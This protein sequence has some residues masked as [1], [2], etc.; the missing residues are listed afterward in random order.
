M[1][2][3]KRLHP[4]KTE[5]FMAHFRVLGLKRGECRVNVIR[6]AAE[7]MSN[8]L[9]HSELHV[10]RETADVRRA[11]IALAAYR[12]LDPRERSNIYER[13]QLTFP[14]DREEVADGVTES[15]S[16]L[17]K[18]AVDSESGPAVT[19]ETGAYKSLVK[20]MNQPLVDEAISGGDLEMGGQ[21]DLSQSQT[22]R[23]GTDEASD[24]TLDERRGIVRLL[25]ESDESTLRSLSP[26]GWLRSRL[27]I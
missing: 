2:F 20:L 21:S 25:R 9:S 14:L 17:D 12:L 15:Q 8:A 18:V 11:R 1:K 7:A 27:G 23:S 6:S 16:F 22:D 13:V 3:N 10:P 4:K 5:A 24:L 19:A 26:L